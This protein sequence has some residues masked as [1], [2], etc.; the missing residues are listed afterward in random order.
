M[1][2]YSYRTVHITRTEF[3]LPADTNAAEVGKAITAA[4]YAREQQGFK[5]DADTSIQVRATDEELIFWWEVTG[6]E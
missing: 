4:Y 1:A 3:F 6:V 2:D 5:N